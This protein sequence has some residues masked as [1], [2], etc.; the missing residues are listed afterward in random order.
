MRMPQLA[1]ATADHSC[2]R[3]AAAMGTCASM[4]P[5]VLGARWPQKHQVYCRW[6]TAALIGLFSELE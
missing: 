3:A 4:M 6:C 2:M 5:Y 1:K